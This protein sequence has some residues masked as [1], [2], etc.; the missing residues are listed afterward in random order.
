[1]KWDTKTEK[2]VPDK[3]RDKLPTNWKD[4]QIQI[5]GHGDIYSERIG[6][7]IPDGLAKKLIN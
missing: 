3:L 7:L 5:V 2:F 4:T 6:N 1:M